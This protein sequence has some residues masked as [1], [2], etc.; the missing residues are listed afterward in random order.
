MA[1]ASTD[2]LRALAARVREEGLVSEFLG[3][4][5]DSAPRAFSRTERCAGNVYRRPMD[6]AKA[7]DRIVG[8]RHKY[9]HV[10]YVIRGAVVARSWTE[11]PKGERTDAK[12][13]TFRAPCAVTVLAGRHHEF[14]ALEDG[15]LAD[16]IFAHRDYTGEVVDAYMG[17][18]GATQ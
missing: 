6:F 9:D 10:T 16:C 3:L 14:V 12:E 13:G 15:T 11:G 7:G 17:N 2:E 8:H 4:L 18:I 1:T 5:I